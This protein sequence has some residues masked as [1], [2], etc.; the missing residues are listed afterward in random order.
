MKD[1]L[2]AQKIS[3]IMPVYNGEK[4]IA[5]AVESIEK[6]TYKNWEII[7]YDD[8][9]ADSTPVYLKKKAETDPRIRVIGESSRKGQ[10][11][12]RNRAIEAA[13]G[14]YLALLDADDLAL[15]SRLEIQYRFMEE[16]PEIEVAGTWTIIR[17][18]NGTEEVY[19][20]ETDPDI[21]SAGLLFHTML[22]NSSVIIRKTFLTENNLS[23]DENSP[24]LAEDYAL[25]AKCAEKGRIANIPLT[26]SVY[27]KHSHSI[28]AEKKKE[29]AERASAVRRAILFKLGL[30][31]TDEEMQLHNAIVPE[32]IA[33]TEFLAKEIKWLEKIQ[34]ANKAVRR[35]DD[36]ALAYI[37]EKRFYS[38]CLA[39]PNL[40]TI[41]I[42]A[43]KPFYGLRHYVYCLKLL[44][45]LL[46]KR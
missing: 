2:N 38:L 17:D 29:H 6:Q 16:H 45:K 31:P 9:S 28:S 20:T 32:N 26:L 33:E 1:M 27:R 37:L 18:E 41:F 21:I 36:A 11:Y 39:H 43:K 44:V 25:W 3:V 8:A 4:Y 10:S 22:V 30:R 15:P 46:F 23:Y 7:I 35:C 42:F 13:H 24:F 34:E 14:T 5:E 19:Q 12:A 40:G